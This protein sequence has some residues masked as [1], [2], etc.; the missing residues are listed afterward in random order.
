MFS[1][2]AAHRVWIDVKVHNDRARR[3]YTAVGFVQEGILRE[4]R[5]CR[6]AI[7]ESLVIMSLLREEWLM[8]AR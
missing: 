1:T 4:R 3:A 5:C 2:C 7:Y 8:H 6:T